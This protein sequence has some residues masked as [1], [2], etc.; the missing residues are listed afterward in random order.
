MVCVLFLL[1][2][3]AISLP[4]IR[5]VLWDPAPPILSR[6]TTALAWWTRR[7]LL[8]AWHLTWWTVPQ[9]MVGNLSAVAFLQQSAWRCQPWAGG[10]GV[11]CC[12]WFTPVGGL[13]WFK[14]R[15]R[16]AR[17]F[18]TVTHTFFIKSFCTACKWV[19]CS[20]Q[21][22]QHS[23]PVWHSC[24]LASIC[25][26]VC[27]FFARNREKNLIFWGAAALAFQCVSSQDCNFRC[28]MWSW[29]KKKKRYA[30]ALAWRSCKLSA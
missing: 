15:L 30:P 4:W 11:A 10:R 8:T 9:V 21:F 3:K 6:W 23:D 25:I 1:V 18:C 5:A 16:Y 13:E 27:M 24:W 28:L 14:T 20:E 12:I 2:G 22:Q 26:F 29:F 7:L 17:F 19:Q